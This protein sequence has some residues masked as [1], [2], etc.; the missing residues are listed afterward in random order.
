MNLQK[1]G[2]AAALL[3]SSALI[4]C[5]HGYYSA[6]VAV[7]PPPP[8]LV[9]GPVGYAPGPGYVW[10]DGYYDLRGSNWV[11]VRGRWARPPHPHA[12]WVKPSWERHGSG[13]RFH[14]GH[15]QR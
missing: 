15:W 8:P 14:E 7:G 1:L 12:R 10:T 13:Y 2:L 3:A 5:S 11:W 9:Y 4:G 6:G